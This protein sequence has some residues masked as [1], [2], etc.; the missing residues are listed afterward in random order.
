M[1]KCKI[2]L[3]GFL[4]I[5]MLF[6]CSNNAANKENGLE[7]ITVKDLK[8]HLE[9]LSADEFLGRD[10]PSNELKIAS[11]YLAKMA[12]N[13]GLKPLM[14]NN[15]YFQLMPLKTTRISASE[16]SITLITKSGNKVYKYLEDFGIG[17]SDVS[18]GIIK[19]DLLFLGLGH[20]TLDNTWDD[21]KDKNITGKVVVI[22]DADLPRTHAL[23]SDGTGMLLRA[24]AKKL[25][26]LGAEAVIKIIDNKREK[27]F[28]EE[29]Y[30]FITNKKSSVLN[31]AKIDSIEAKLSY[32]SIEVR[33]QMASDILG[34]STQEINN[35]FVEL[36]KGNQIDGHDILNKTIHIK[37]QVDKGEDNSRNVLAYIEGS[38][39]KLK[40]EFVILGAHYDHIGISENG[41]FNGAN[42][43]G[44]GTVGLLETAQAMSAQNPERSV[45]FVWFTGEEKGLWGSKYFVANSPIPLEKIS[46]VINLDVISGTDMD[47]VTVTGGEVLSSTLENLISEASKNKL[48]LDYMKETP[49]TY[50]F[51]FTRSDHFPFL[52]NGIPSVWLG[53]HSDDDNHV[54][55]VNDTAEAVNFEKMEKITKL[56]YLLGLEIANYPTMM[57]LDVNPSITKR[58]AHNTD[59]DW[60]KEI[61]KN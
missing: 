38:N 12:K 36:K 15:S 48:K 22:L 14:P 33:H 5:V 31:K 27:Q 59:F 54:H 55:H 53:A 25:T 51:F 43:N 46:A 29:E 6:G 23:R 30:Q 1:K 24:R 4:V 56:S 20:Q 21:L 44:S 52:M 18:S 37:V 32:N 11:Q 34:I 61:K 8:H 40:D 10:T 13:Y 42:D 9:F 17:D 60:Q 16:T 7:S 39:P 58:G 49:S 57:S 41:V 50:Q 45:L 2:I 28:Q 19:G 3:C 26:E 47:K 35:M